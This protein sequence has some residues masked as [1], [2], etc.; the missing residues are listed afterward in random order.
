MRKLK[1]GVCYLNVNYNWNEDKRTVACHLKYGININRIP[2]IEMIEGYLQFSNGLDAMHIEEYENSDNGN[3]DPYIIGE[4]VGLA[5]C[6]PDDTFDLEL[7]KKIAL[8]RAQS[9]AFKDASTFWINLE[10]IMLEAAN[11]FNTIFENCV[12]SENKC[13]D[14]LNNKLLK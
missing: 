6:D 12:E 14:H 8:T 10:D 13:N 1:T 4:T 3:I 5:Y 2:Y 11:R 7:G 9:A